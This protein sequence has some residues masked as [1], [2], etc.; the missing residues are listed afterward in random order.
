MKVFKHVTLN[1]IK[2]KPFPFLRELTMEAYLIENEDVLILDDDNF[3]RIKILDSELTLKY[4][5]MNKDTDGRIDLLALY[6]DNTLGI[7][8]L[9][10]GELTETH[11]SQLE[12]YFKVKNQILEK[13]KNEIQKEQENEVKWVGILIGTSISET[14]KQKIN[15]GYLIENN[16][17]LAALII[18]RYKSDDNQIYVFTE[19]YFKN[20]SRNFDRTQYK[21]DNQVYRKG[22]LVLAIIKKYVQNNPEITYSDLEKVFPPN[23]QGSIGVFTTFENANK[24]FQE[25][26]YKRYFLNQ[27]DLISLN[28]DVKIAVSNQWGKDNI[29][30]IIKKAKDLKYNIE[31]IPS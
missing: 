16:I 23:F 19:T 25:T 26:E 29:D 12:D 8:E 5:R 10:I 28:N 30:N 13:Y 24:I 4:G 18:N 3:E 2:L 7:I 22:K 11:L 27:E 6:N 21:F 9:K 15:N 17:P 1:N 31:I 20:I 14:L